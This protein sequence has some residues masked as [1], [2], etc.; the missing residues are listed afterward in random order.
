MSTRDPRT[1][2]LAF[3]EAINR[4]D[5]PAALEYL[6]EDATWWLPP[7]LPGVGGTHRGRD[8]ILRD[9]MVPVAALFQPGSL[10]IEPVGTTVEGERVAVEWVARARST[11]DA[12]YEN[13]YH[14]LFEV[15]DGRILAVREYL[16][17]LTVQRT[18]F[19]G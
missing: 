11:A 7:A 16:D 13:H 8:A 17:A 19:A 15:R 3:I 12:P 14:V 10:R 9:F 4:N 1:V 5:V 18:L 6:A 2:V